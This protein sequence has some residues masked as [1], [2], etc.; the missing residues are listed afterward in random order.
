M[1]TPVFKGCDA[2]CAPIIECVAATPAPSLIGGDRD[3]HGC[4]IAA[5]YSWCESKQKCLR[6]WEENCSDECSSDADC[7]IGGCSHELC[8]AKSAGTPV[9][10]CIW[11]P[12][13][14]CYKLS[15]CRCI[16]GGC[17]WDLNDAFEK[18]VLNAS[19]ATGLNWTKIEDGRWRAEDLACLNKQPIAYLCSSQCYEKSN[20]RV[21][22]LCRAQ[23]EV[24]TNSE[25]SEVLCF[26]QGCFPDSQSLSQGSCQLVCPL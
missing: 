22:Q 18:C 6:V 5:G 12:E 25:G 4:L 23:G 3:A 17:G 16:S 24:K 10:S 7:V 26:S 20:A 8:A 2:T 13:Y 15:R 21:W 1:K 11:K 19:G 9:S 14:A